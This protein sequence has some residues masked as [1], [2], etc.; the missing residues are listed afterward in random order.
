M[1]QQESKNQSLVAG[2]YADLERGDVEGVIKTLSHDV[3]WV[4]APGL[5][6][7]GTYTGHEAVGGIFSTYGD[8]WEDLA[9]IPDKI[10]SAGDHVIALG[11]YEARGHATGKEMRA[12]FAHVWRL[13]D[14]VP[15][16]FETIA[17]THT[18][19]AAMMS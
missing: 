11:H 7:G 6:Y 9:V 3:S 5:P 16:S 18:M 4:V 17:D 8:V 19:V 12:R 14:G 1:S 10:V 13:E 15:V 2:L